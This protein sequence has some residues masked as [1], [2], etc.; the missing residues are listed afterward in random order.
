MTPSHATPAT[1]VHAL[2]E[3]RSDTG[4]MIKIDV[5]LPVGVASA[6]RFGAYIGGAGLLPSEVAARALD[7]A[8]GDP[9]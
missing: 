5:R 3:T 4:S 1:D 2:A 8:L 6:L 9:R 7:R